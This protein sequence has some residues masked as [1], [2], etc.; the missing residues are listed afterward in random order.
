M[1]EQPRWHGEAWFPIG[2]GLLWLWAGAHGG[3]MT[4][5]VAAPPALLLLASGGSTLLWPGDHR[6]PHFMALGGVLLLWM[7]AEVDQNS[8]FITSCI[9]I[10]DD[11][12]FVLGNQL[13]NRFD[14]NHNLAITD[15]IWLVSL[16]Q[17]AL[18]VN[19]L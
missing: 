15:E 12:S 2:A 17:N 13:L 18:A 5:A 7:A 6:I 8:Q 16:F 1:F 3:P 10:I 9:K 4:F 11:L 19:E 14:F